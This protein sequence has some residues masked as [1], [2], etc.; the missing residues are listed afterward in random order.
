MSCLL[1]TG[2]SSLPQGCPPLSWTRP[3]CQQ[4]QHCLED[5]GHWSPAVLGGDLSPKGLAVFHC[6]ALPAFLEPT[7]FSATSVVLGPCPPG[8]PPWDPEW[9]TQW[10]LAGPLLSPHISCSLLCA[11]GCQEYNHTGCPVP[12]SGH[13]VL[14]S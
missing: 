4:A 13:T 6:L 8:Q 1:S 9:A 10:K 7:V 5:L 2:S 12:H 14:L 11:Q 3:P